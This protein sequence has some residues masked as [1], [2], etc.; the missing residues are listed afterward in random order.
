MISREARFQI[1]RAEKLLREREAR[2]AR[3]KERL[4]EV[5][6]MLRSLGA[7]EV[8][9]F[10]SVDQAWFHERSDVDLAVLGMHEPSYEQALV[11]ATE[12]LGEAVDL[13]RLED[14]EQGLARHVRET[15]ERIA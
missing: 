4:P 13:V 10:G 11:R 12:I 6:S 5:A 8:W 9:L 3:I 2:R 1:E 15:G 7:Q 14:A